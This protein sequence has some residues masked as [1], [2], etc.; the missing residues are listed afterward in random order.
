MD[1]ELL[2]DPLGRCFGVYTA[3]AGGAVCATSVG[4]LGPSGTGVYRMLVAGFAPTARRI[5]PSGTSAVFALAARAWPL[6]VNAALSAVRDVVAAR[7][8]EVRCV[9]ETDEE[10]PDP[11]PDPEPEP[12]AEPEEEACMDAVEGGTGEDVPEVMGEFFLD[13]AGEEW[14]M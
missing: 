5:T 2:L 11:E 1:D 13:E 3:Y 6:T 8:G 12:E 9:E 14:A 7:E 10:E 4:P